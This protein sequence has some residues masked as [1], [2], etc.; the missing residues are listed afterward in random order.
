MKI[1][2]IG[3]TDIFINNFIDIMYLNKQY[4][5]SEEFVSIDIDSKIDHLDIRIIKKRRKDIL[6]LKNKTNIILKIIAAIMLFLAYILFFPFVLVYFA[7]SSVPFGEI[8]VYQYNFI[9][10]NLNEDDNIIL[11]VK[12]DTHD[13]LT[14]W[15]ITSEKQVLDCK[16]T[17]N[18]QHL[19]EQKKLFLRKTLFLIL[20]YTMISVI[21]ILIGL[22][23]QFNG[24]LGV[25]IAYLLV[26][27]CVIII[28]FY[29]LKKIRNKIQFIY[30]HEGS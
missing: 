19:K 14:E 9:Y 20:P 25:G 12:K 21:C 8:D 28:I 27:F 7:Y 10:R 3:N 29:K 22:I 15:E 24:L 18:I 4:V 23:N 17:L 6:R 11:K 2:F 1:S 26:V 13:F 5:L 16:K 30:D